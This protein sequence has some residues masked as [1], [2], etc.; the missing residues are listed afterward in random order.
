MAAVAA[1]PE[2]ASPLGDVNAPVEDDGVGLRLYMARQGKFTIGSVGDDSTQCGFAGARTLDYRVVIEGDCL[3][4][5]PEGFI[6]DN[7]AI[8]RYFDEKYG[9]HVD[10]FLSCEH[11]AMQAVRDFRKAVQ[12]CKS[13]T[14]TI[15][16]TS[17]AAGLTAS[18]RS[19]GLDTPVA[20]A[21]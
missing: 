6:I 16:G 13:V 9:G 12:G 18:W 14:V 19:D 10:R 17:G 8:Q 20:G 11:I 15:D 1:A 21:I 2:Y 4:L 3:K 5:T 7:F